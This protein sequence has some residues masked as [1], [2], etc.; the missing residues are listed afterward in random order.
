MKKQPYWHFCHGDKDGIARLGYGDNR[1]V[2]VGETLTVAGEPGLCEH[3]LHASIDLWDALVYAPE[4]A[5]GFGWS[6]C[7]VE[8]SGEVVHGDEKSVASARKV[9]AML[10]T[11]A[12]DKL[13]RDYARWCALQVIHLWDAP[14]IVRQYLETG[15]AS[16]RD[17][18]WTAADAAARAAAR[19]ERISFRGAVV[20]TK[21]YWEAASAAARAAANAVATDAAMGAASAATD[22][23]ARGADWIVATEAAWAEYAEELERRAIAAMGQEQ[24][25]E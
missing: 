16:I 6:L 5:H 1:Q 15:D 24:A 7:R 20:I 10:N 18:A 21:A 14:S 23:A 2:K 3:G 8:L 9:I 22:V 17:A 11:G 19:A 12:T 4:H 25:H 13:L